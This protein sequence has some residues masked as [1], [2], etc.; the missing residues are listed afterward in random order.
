M[1]AVTPEL[2]RRYDVPGPRY[3][4][5]PTADRFVE[6]F[7]DSDY[8]L[9]LKQRKISAAAKSPMSLYVH[10]PFCNSLCYYCACNKIITK[11]HERAVTYLQYL[12]RELDLHLA[13]CGKGQLVS[14]LHIGGGTPTFLSDEQ[15]VQMWDMLRQRFVFDEAGEYSI[16]V[17]PRTVTRE[18]LAALKAMG[19]NRLSFGVQDFDPDVQKA[20]HREQPAEQVFDLVAASRE[21]GFESINVDLIYGLPKQ[22][23]KSFARTL[24]QVAELRPDRIALY[25]YAHLPER[26]KP[27]R[28]ILQADLPAAADKVN[29][30]AA[31]LDSFMEAGYVYVGM[32]H[33]A[34]PEDSLAVAKRQGRLHR[35][36]QGYSTQPDCDL[37]ALGVS[38]IG[39]VGATYSQN[40]KTLEEYYDLLDQGRLPIVRG[41]ALSRD[42]MLRRAVIMA[43]MCQGEVQYE[44][45]NSAWLIDF[46][47]YF[48]A[49]IEALRTQEEEGL[50][51]ILDDC[52]RVTAKGWFFVRGVALVFDRYLQE[53]RDRA[54]FSRII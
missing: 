38:A 32:D 28:R 50:V 36:F 22:N 10:I 9:A 47:K 41:L 7:G 51:E 53:A 26:F 11:H 5:Y 18:R 34:L 29:M 24:Q 15:L 21:L 46:R 25:A 40:A 8:I 13:H 42:D 54:R 49:E 37:I 52:I 27:Q 4:S 48:A 43:I 3:T 20:V 44:S 16:E 35:N 17:D 12:E 33:F 39:R 19:F 30:L 6:A 2:L 1:T 45:I 14:Q 23:E 31:A